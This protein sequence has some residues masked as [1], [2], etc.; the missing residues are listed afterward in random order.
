MATKV[1]TMLD[2]KY[3]AQMVIVGMSPETRYTL[4]EKWPEWREHIAEIEVTASH[5][6]QGAE[7]QTAI[8]VLALELVVMGRLKAGLAKELTER[9]EPMME[10]IELP[11][12]WHLS[13]APDA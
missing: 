1:T 4:T 3:T 13:G 9:I 8:S 5:I 12:L 2:R 10:V 6:V 11:E 7:F